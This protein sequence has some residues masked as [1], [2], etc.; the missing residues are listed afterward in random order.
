[1]TTEEYTSRCP[2]MRW[3]RAPED[4]HLVHSH[5]CSKYNAEMEVKV[6]QAKESERK[7]R[8]CSEQLQKEGS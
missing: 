3:C 1:M 5:H 6:F 7:R 2:C 4:F 8:V